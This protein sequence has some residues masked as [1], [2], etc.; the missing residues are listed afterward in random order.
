MISVPVPASSVTAAGQTVTGPA[1]TIPVPAQTVSVPVDLSP[2][3]PY[4]AAIAAAGWTPTTAPATQ[5]FLQKLG[6]SFGAPAADGWHDGTNFLTAQANLGQKVTYLLWWGQV[7]VATPA[8]EVSV[9]NYFYSTVMK[10]K[11]A[12]Q[13]ASLVPVYTYGYLPSGGS[14]ATGATGAYNGVHTQIANAFVANGAANPVVRIMHE[15]SGSWNPWF[16]GG[17]NDARAAAYA[18][19]WKQIVAAW[20]AAY[21]GKSLG[22]PRFMWCD[23]A[24]TTINPTVNAWPGSGYVDLV[25]VDFY[26]TN[27][28]VAKTGTGTYATWTDPTAAFANQRKWLWGLDSMVAFAKAQGLPCGL[29]EW[30][31]WGDLNNPSAGGGDDPAFIQMMHDWI[32]DPANNVAFAVQFNDSN[33]PDNNLL[34]ASPTHMPNAKAKLVAL[35]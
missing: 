4:A 5:T 1:Q 16:I 24:N 13:A 26:D 25:G 19:Y 3:G 27:A 30:S 20:R 21:L 35:A 18:G 28:N 31:T 33:N 17:T 34:Y 8:A 11:L 9:I 14:L 15:M 32:M 7:K 10:G 23:L 22:V 2:T 12:A 6:L 29:G